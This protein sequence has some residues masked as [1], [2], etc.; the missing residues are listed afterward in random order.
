M[1]LVWLSHARMQMQAA[2][3]TVASSP[4][5]RLG[6]KTGLDRAFMTFTLWK[7]KYKRH[8]VVRIHHVNQRHPTGT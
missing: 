3:A 4:V 7:T 5:A 2:L 6:K 8:V 1:S